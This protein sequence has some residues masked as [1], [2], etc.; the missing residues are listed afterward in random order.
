MYFIVQHAR[1][2]FFISF[3]YIHYYVLSLM[4]LE[5]HMCTY[6]YITILKIAFY[7]IVIE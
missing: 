3:V 1:T 5:V 6:I 7:S 4:Y 2:L